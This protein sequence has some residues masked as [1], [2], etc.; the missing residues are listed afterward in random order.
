M[1]YAVLI[2]ISLTFISCVRYETKEKTR[3]CL[4]DLDFY[5]YLSFQEGVISAEQKYRV[6]YK[7]TTN[8][9]GGEDRSTYEKRDVGKCELTCEEGFIKYKLDLE[10]DFI[11]KKNSLRVPDGICIE[12]RQCKDISIKEVAKGDRTIDRSDRDNYFEYLESPDCVFSCGEN[13]SIDSSDEENM[14]CVS[15]IMECSGDELGEGQVSASKS[16]N[17]ESNTYDSCIVSECSQGYSLEDNECK[18]DGVQGCTNPTA[19]NFDPQ[20]T[21]DDGSCA[22]GPGFIFDPEVF[23]CIVDVIL[24]CPQGEY[25]DLGSN[26][27][28][29]FGFLDS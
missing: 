16:W 17:E 5:N 20:A 22:C 3:N 1:K 11:A 18:V 19:I 25:L 28:V 12:E 9:N 15:S 29:P 2:L 14:Q 27:C 13:F 7:Y 23:Q 26:Q 8:P 4:P 24:E 10:S 21:V 6:T